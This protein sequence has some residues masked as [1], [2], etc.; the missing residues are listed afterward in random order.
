VVFVW[1]F[2]ST[3]LRDAWAGASRVRWVHVA[4]AGVEPLLF[5]ELRTARVLLTNSRGVFDGGIAEFVLGAV[6]AF[7]KDLPGTIR[8]QREHIWRHRES[9]L[10]AGSNVVVVGAGSIGCAVGRLLNAVGCNVV[11]IARRAREEPGFDRVVPIEQF[12]DEVEHADI[13][14]ITAPL[15]EQTAGLLDAAVFARTRSSALLVN[16]GRGPI[17]DEQALLAALDG[18][19]LRAAVLDVFDDEPLSADHPF[20][21]RPDVIVSPHMSGDFE[22]FA[23]VLVDLFAD[24]FA[25]WR[26]GKQLHNIVDLDRGY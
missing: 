19:R 11:G 12:G 20:W 5:P 13:V 24:N 18:G 23:D 17:V 14:V 6:L 9:K 4:S 25:R 16:V 2:R 10:V 15:T 3:V 26:A 7:A 22:G 8:L 1:D 21:D